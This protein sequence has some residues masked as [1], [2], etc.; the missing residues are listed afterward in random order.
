MIAEIIIDLIIIFAKLIYK[1]VIF[2]FQNFRG[3]SQD[4]QLNV[5][6][7]PQPA[8]VPS[9][10]AAFSIQPQNTVEEKGE[11]DNGR[12][13]LNKSLVTPAEQTFL[14]VLEQAVG[15]SYRIVPQVPLSAI[16]S[17][18]DSNYHYTNYRDFNRIK[19][20][21]VDFVLYDKINWT[22][23]LV[24]EL[25]DRSHL[26]WKRIQRDVF[27]DDVLG[28]VGLGILHVPVSCEYDLKGLK[29][30]IGTKVKI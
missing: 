15:D 2:A 18:K 7:E 3:K 12:Y 9:Y 22:P 17:P 30:D 29:E 23:H 13:N 6:N 21:K 26:Q 28:R 10:Q 11:D 8:P 25:D 1:L 24:I 27:V 16:V 4:F 14:K 20:K 5:I 19:A